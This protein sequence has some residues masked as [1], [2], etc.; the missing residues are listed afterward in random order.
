MTYRVGAS[1]SG[2]GEGSAATKRHV[3][4]PTRLGKTFRLESSPLDRGRG[5]RGV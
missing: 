3:R 5:G 1:A 2:S 4:A